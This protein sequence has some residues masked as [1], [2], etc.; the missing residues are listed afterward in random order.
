M[1]REKGSLPDPGA[2]NS[3]VWEI[4]KQIP[5][6]KVATYGQIA[7]MIPVPQGVSAEEYSRYRARWVGHAMAGS[8]EGVPWQR[9]INSQGR[10][11]LKE[12]HAATQRNLLEEEGVLFDQRQRIDLD[13]YGWPGPPEEWL[14]E[15]HLIP[16]PPKYHQTTLPI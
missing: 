12:A 5:P 4:V 6:G 11:S 15:R 14:A 3:I 10:I 9:V 13:R 1:D 8:P 2:F 7:E 16:P